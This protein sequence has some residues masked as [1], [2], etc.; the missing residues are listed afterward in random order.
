M[1]KTPK[2]PKVETPPPPPTPPSSAD[3]SAGVNSNI[4]SDS[5]SAARSL[6]NTGGSGLATKAK[7]SKRSLIGG[8]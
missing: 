4:A 8:A 1:F 6:I 3:A 7:T 5:V 2:P